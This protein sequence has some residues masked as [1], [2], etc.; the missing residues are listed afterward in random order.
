M[1]SQS[2]ECW[3]AGLKIKIKLDFN[4]K[5]IILINVKIIRL[6]SFYFKRL[7]THKKSFIE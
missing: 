1:S 7:K 5:K 6:V 2:V 3:F 4:R